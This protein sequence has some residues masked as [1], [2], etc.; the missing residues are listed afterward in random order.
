LSNPR[1]NSSHSDSIH[2]APQE[3]KTLPGWVEIGIIVAA[4]GL[5]GEVR[6]YPDSDFP[7]RF[8]QPG[9][10]WLLPPG[11]TEPQAVQLLQGRYLQPKRLYVV[12]FAEIVNR[13]QAEAL[14]GYRLVV[15]ES[16]R[17]PLEAGEFHILDLVGLEV[18]DQQ[19]QA[20]LGSVTGVVS[21]GNDLL[22]VK[23]KASCQEPIL[24]PLV[25]EIVPVIDLENKR[26]EITP[27]PGLLE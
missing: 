26:I 1:S 23:P 16:D 24:I 12:Q 18:F 14:K 19:T 11:A 17:P 5:K 13:T 9:Q 3:P 6:V 8:E 4:Q 21:A 25:K 10:R 7:A 27:P 22:E 2:P 20:I 15:P